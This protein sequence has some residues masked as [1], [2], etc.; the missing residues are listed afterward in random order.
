V[1]WG[2]PETRHSLSSVRNV[3]ID[4]P[5]GGHV[6]LGQVADVRV[7]AAPLVIR[8]QDDSR[9]LDVVAGVDGRSVGD[10]TDDVRAALT[11]VTFPLEYH[12]EVVNDFADRRAEGVRGIAVVIAVAIAILLLLQAAF[13][14]WRLAAVMFVTTFLALAG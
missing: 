8:H 12:A 13:S 10:V 7:G 4:I 9:T 11:G 14:S 5:G 6:R 1:V 2:T 3:L